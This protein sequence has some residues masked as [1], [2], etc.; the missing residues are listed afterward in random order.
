MTELDVLKQFLLAIFCPERAKNDPK[1]GFLGF[2]K[3]VLIFFFV[4]MMGS[5]NWNRAPISFTKHVTGNIFVFQKVIAQH[6]D[7][8][9]CIII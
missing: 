6:V 7:Q 4:K 9:N 2:L 1:I 5:K 3:N 8:L